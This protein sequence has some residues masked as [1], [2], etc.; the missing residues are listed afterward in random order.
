MPRQFRSAWLKTLATVA[1]LMF[2]FLLWRA[3][4]WVSRRRLE[5]AEH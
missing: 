2:A 4:R 3:L 1:V 5:T